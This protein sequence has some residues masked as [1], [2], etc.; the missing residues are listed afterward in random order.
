MMYE[1]AFFGFKIFTGELAFFPPI[2][3][4]I[5]GRINT[6]KSNSHAMVDLECRDHK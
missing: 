3:P 5:D 1:F 4:S 2:V 6:G